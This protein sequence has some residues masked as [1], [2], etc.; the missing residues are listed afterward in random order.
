MGVNNP[1]AFA[2]LKERTREEYASIQASVVALFEARLYRSLW[3]KERDG[4]PPEVY[5]GQS[6]MVVFKLNKRLFGKVIKKCKGNYQKVKTSKEYEMFLPAYH[7]GG[8]RKE[9]KILRIWNL[10][11]FDFTDLL[12]TAHR[13]T[14]KAYPKDDQR[15]ILLK[16]FLDC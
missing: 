10:F 9:R 13:G 8:V 4:E 2:S 5:N 7:S 1:K 3:K 14:V 16:D 11:G 12:W 15:L 6:W